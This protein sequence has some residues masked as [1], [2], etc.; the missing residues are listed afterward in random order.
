M[1]RDVSAIC[2]QDLEA[3]RVEHGDGLYAD[4]RFV[5]SD[6]GAAARS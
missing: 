5:F 1:K 4:E 3:E 6:N 2:L